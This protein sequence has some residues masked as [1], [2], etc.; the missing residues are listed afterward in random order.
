[1]VP[2]DKYFKPKSLTWWAAVSLLVHAVLT[3]DVGQALEALAGI[4]LRGKL[5]Q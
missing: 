1:M 5:G 3:K 4:G 2:V